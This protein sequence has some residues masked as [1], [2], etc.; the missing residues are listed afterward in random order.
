MTIAPSKAA[1]LPLPMPTPDPATVAQQARRVMM[2]K[3]V[4]L[5]G[6]ATRGRA[7]GATVAELRRASPLLAALPAS[8]LE[9]LLAICLYEG[10]L[11]GPVRVHG[12]GV[13]RIA[14]VAIQYL[15]RA[16]VVPLS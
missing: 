3:V 11:V 13:K 9:A 1:Q 5:L 4:D 8:E 16:K 15:D 2:T 12:P 6:I 14:Y 7:R 10:G